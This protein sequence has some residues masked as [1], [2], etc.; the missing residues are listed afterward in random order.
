M[1][2]D[3]LDGRIGEGWG[4]LA[5]N[6]A[7]VNVVLAR[8]GSPTA[9]AA[10][11]MF[12]HPSP[13]HTPVLCCV[14]PSQQE[15]E[16]IWPPTLM[17]N[18]A[19]ATEAR[20]ET[21]TWG[22]A[23]LGIGQGVLDAVADGLLEASGDILVLVAVWVAA[24]AEN[25]TA[26][27]EAARTAVRKAI[28]MCVSGRDPEAAAQAR[29]RPR[30]APQPLLRRQLMRITAVEARRYRVDFDPPFRAAW[31][32]I[33]RDHQEATLVG[34]HTDEG[35]TGWASGDALPNHEQLESLLVGL[36]PFRTELVRELEETVDFHGGR[37]WTVEA[38]VWDLLGKATGQPVWKLLGGRS[39]RLLAYVSSGELVE[40][41]E[42]A[43]R[44]VALRD[45][46]VKAVKIRFHHADWRD[47]VRVVK[48][49]RDAV[50]RDLE[51]MVDANQGWR[52]AGDLEPRWDVAT[53]AQVARVLEPL[54]VYWLEEPLR[55]DDL[56]GYAA[57]RGL[58]SLR[59]AAGRDGALRPGGARSHPPGQNRRPP[60]RRRAVARDR[61]LPPRGSARRSGRAAPGRPTP[62]RTATACSSTCMRRSRSPPCPSSRCRSTH[63][64]GRPSAVTGCCRRLS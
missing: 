24:N 13:G 5:P 56:D 46:G 42:R 26:V 25:E 43:R 7:H 18:K 3:E 23:Q 41:D 60:V 35:V 64:P 16:P 36:D 39:E 15:Y 33:P 8:R 11:S 37:A 45:A 40:P 52:M 27:R 19:T 48:A 62:G 2:L 47:D 58:T 21:I 32:P 57:L 14:G 49:V 44:C 51:I 4:G 30:H 31:D 1:N 9:A 54:G 20:H 34:V 10:L 53:A 17:M 59:I 12:A 28:G 63:P 50:G 22:A 38:A 6:G 55:T 29:G 61:W